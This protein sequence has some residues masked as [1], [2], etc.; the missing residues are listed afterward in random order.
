MVFF[1]PHFTSGT[2]VVVGAADELVGASSCGEP[3]LLHAAPSDTRATKSAIRTR[4]LFRL[5]TAITCGSLRTTSDASWSALVGLK[6]LRAA[7]G[8]RRR[9]RGGATSTSRGPRSDGCAHG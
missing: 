9:P 8:R 1:A 3:L 4:T 5:R 2:T 6:R 7:R